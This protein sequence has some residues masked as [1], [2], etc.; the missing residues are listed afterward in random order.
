[1]TRKPRAV[2][3]A[4]RDAERHERDRAAVAL[5]GDRAVEQ[6]Q[7]ED[8]RVEA[9]GGLDEGVAEARDQHLGGLGVGPDRQP[10]AAVLGDGA[11]V[12]EAVQVI[13]VRV[14]VEDAVEEPDPGVEELG[15]QVGGGVDQ[16]AG[17]AGGGGALDEQRAAAAAVLRVRGVAVAPVAADAG[18]AGGGAAAEDWR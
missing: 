14:G 1:M 17:G 13:G 16:D 15:A 18:D 3:A 5:D 11:Q 4:V 6:L 8:R 7:V 9:A 12:V 10:G 2:D